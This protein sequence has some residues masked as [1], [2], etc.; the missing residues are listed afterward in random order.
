[1][2]NFY[3][4]AK[5]NGFFA[6][7][8]KELYINSKHGWPDD[9]VKIT[10]SLY[11]KL[12]QGQNEGKVIVPDSK[13]RPKL[14]EPTVDFVAVAEGLRLTLLEKARRKISDW[15]TE[16]ELNLINEDDKI[17]LIKW[18]VYIRELKE[19]DVSY[20]SKNSDLQEIDWPQEPS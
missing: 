20:V 3:F 9:S 15:R 18:M 11:K 8:D 1:M 10:E 17:S 13:G 6:E 7:N 14:M 19:V 5:V 2:S 4:S 16:L 12:M